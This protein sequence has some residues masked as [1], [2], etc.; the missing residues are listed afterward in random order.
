M[1]TLSVPHC[2]NFGGYNINKTSFS[3]QDAQALGIDKHIDNANAWQKASYV[4]MEV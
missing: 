2:G 3:L 1:P 4:V